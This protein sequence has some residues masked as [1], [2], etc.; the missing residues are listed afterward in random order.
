[1]SLSLRWYKYKLR[2]LYNQRR[3]CQRQ[4]IHL[5]RR[6]RK[7]RWKI[8]NIAT[9]L[10]PLIT[11]VVYLDWISGAA[12]Q[13][14]VKMP[15][16][17]PGLEKKIEGDT[18]AWNYSDQIGSYPSST[19]DIIQGYGE[20]LYCTVSLPSGYSN[21]MRSLTL[22]VNDCDSPIYT[23]ETAFLPEIVDSGGGTGSGST[24]ST[25]GEEMGDGSSGG[26]TSGGGSDPGV[27]VCGPA[28]SCSSGLSPT[29]CALYG[30]TYVTPFCTTSPCLPS[31]CACP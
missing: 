25:S 15:G 16:G 1:M 3:N 9:P 30:G 18:G 28:G 7:H 4:R 20:R 5:H 19:C 29:S 23:N 27:E 26:E 10:K 6:L 17:I 31:F 24:G 11:F 22:K 8:P 13:F 12:L 21:S 2:S 14:Y